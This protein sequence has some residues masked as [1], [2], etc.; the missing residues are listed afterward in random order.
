MNFDYITPAWIKEKLKE[1]GLSQADLAAAI[2]TNEP[3]FSGWMNEK[4]KMLNTTKAAIYYYFEVRRCQKL[5]DYIQ[6]ICK[7][8]K[9]L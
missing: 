8:T 9:K 1:E 5:R 4:H 3:T 7:E 2:G 6:N